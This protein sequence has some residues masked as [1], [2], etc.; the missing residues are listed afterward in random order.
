MGGG[1]V[2]LLAAAAIVVPPHLT[3]SFIVAMSVAGGV[4]ALVYLAAQRFLPLPRYAAS[5]NLL[6]RV[7]RAEC[8]RV[9]RGCPLPYACAIGAGFLFVLF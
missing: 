7:I 5:R 4:L 2:K 3:I 8:W 1:D 9:H 6:T